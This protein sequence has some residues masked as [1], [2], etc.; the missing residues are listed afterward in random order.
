MVVSY[1]VVLVGFRVVLVVV[2]DVHS[3]VAAGLT[4]L[5][6]LYHL[7]AAVFRGPDNCVSSF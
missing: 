3:V 5:V 2:L 4:F 7:L 1:A 6:V